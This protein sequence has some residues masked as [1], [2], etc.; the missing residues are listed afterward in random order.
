[1]LQTNATPTENMKT[2]GRDSKQPV[3]I[4]PPP[5]HNKTHPNIPTNTTLPVT[6]SLRESSSTPV[7]NS[8]RAS[9]RG[10][11]PISPVE[12]KQEDNLMTF[13]SVP[14]QLIAA[15]NHI[16]FPNN[17]YPSNISVPG[18]QPS[19]M[20]SR[21][22]GNQTSNLH[23]DV[24]SSPR[25]SDDLIVLDTIKATE[26]MK[27]QL[28]STGPFETDMVIVENRP[29]PHPPRAVATNDT[30]EAKRVVNNPAQLSQSSPRQ[31]VSKVSP[32]IST[33]QVTAPRSEQ[34]WYRD[35]FGVSQSDVKCVE[36]IQLWVKAEMSLAKGDK[37]V[38][39]LA[40]KKVSGE[41]YIEYILANNGV[42]VHY[43]ESL[44]LALQ[45]PMTA[46]NKAKVTAKRNEAVKRADDLRR[47]ME[48]DKKLVV[49]VV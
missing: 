7:R 18:N 15:A 10:I 16:P 6:N 30:G 43:I 34:L 29:S 5:L 38:A 13:E 42:G 25:V 3:I 2:G 11:S 36:A 9:P 49:Q 12:D 27:Y 14:S 20:P 23:S 24:S 44:Q 1:V 8:P 41:Y 28:P 37:A 21:L 40:F 31:H 32:H 45:D 22:T 46:A 33:N 47:D 35:G 39:L 19:S 48:S 17:T 26:L 4:P